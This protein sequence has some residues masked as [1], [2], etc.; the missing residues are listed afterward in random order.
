MPPSGQ[1]AASRFSADVLEFLRLLERHEVDYVIVGGVAVILHGY[2]RL[3]GDIDFFYDRTLENT[4]RLFNALHE[5]WQGKIPDLENAA[6]LMEDGMVLQY[7]R[8][9]Y[10]ID[11]LNK[12]DGV[13]FAEAWL[14]RETT[15]VVGAGE[16]VTVSY[17]GKEALI[18]NKRAS[19]RGRDLDDVEHLE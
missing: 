7:G 15:K 8:P 17:L 12:I 4:G 11:L 18:T 19:G 16:P 1:I 6:E 2:P 5:F 10:R 3:T 14:G 13:T 9:P